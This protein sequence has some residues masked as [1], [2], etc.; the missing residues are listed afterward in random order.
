MTKLYITHITVRS[1]RSYIVD[2]T[3]QA[4][5]TWYQTHIGNDISDEMWNDIYEICPTGC[6]RYDELNNVSFRQI[7]FS[8]NLKQNHNQTPDLN[9]KY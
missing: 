9:R 6:S 4:V 5:N 1:C 2:N 3:R 8:P 7:T